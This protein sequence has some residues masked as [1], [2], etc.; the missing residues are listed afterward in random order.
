VLGLCAEAGLVDVGVSRSTA[1]AGRR[2]PIGAIRTYEQ[3]AEEILPRP[4]A[5]TRRG[6]ALR[7][8]RGDEL[9]E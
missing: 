7:D 5:S 4:L 9:P 3:I 1:Q 2:P 6:R 8:A